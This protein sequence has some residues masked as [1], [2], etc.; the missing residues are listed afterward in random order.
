MKFLRP[1]LWRARN[2]WH[3]RDTAVLRRLQRRGRVV[4]GTGSYGIPTIYTFIHDDT[5]MIVGNYSSIGGTYLLGGQ[6]NVNHVTTY[7][8]RIQFEMD[9]A[10]TDDVPVSRGDIHVGSDVWTGYGCFVPSGT[11]IGDGAVVATGAVVTK[12]VPPYAIVGGSPAKLIRYRHTEEQ[13]EALL[14]IRWW[15]W[16]EEDVREAVPYLASEDIDAFIEFARTRQRG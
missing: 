1:Q 5:R 14:Q 9:G 13:R 6:H 8:L 10:G 3:G 7:P 16:P 12:D 15:D 2:L 4:Y 11:T